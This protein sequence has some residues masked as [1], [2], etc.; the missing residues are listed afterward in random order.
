MA[1]VSQLAKTGSQHQERSV[2]V[3]EDLKGKRIINLDKNIYS[4]GRDSRNSITITS[5]LVSRHHATLLR[6]T[7]T[8]SHE[9]LFQII[10]GDLQG[11][12]S[13]NGLI[14][15]GKKCLYRSLEHK[16]YI[17]FGGHAKAS[18]LIVNSELS[19]LQILECYENKV[20]ENDLHEVVDPFETLVP[21]EIEVK[22]LNEAALLRLAS[23]PELLPSPIIEIDL[24]GK[25]TYLNPAAIQQFPN[26]QK[27]NISHPIIEDYWKKLKS[28][29]NYFLLEIYK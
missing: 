22:P 20:L 29:K 12:R 24:I 7:S 14:V 18:Y 9:D 11:T 17:V 8:E 4:L 27:A 10:D 1:V 16:D 23:F 13:T 6:L 26:I 2:L 5:P 19:E 25:T 28:T 3:L 15:N 21:S